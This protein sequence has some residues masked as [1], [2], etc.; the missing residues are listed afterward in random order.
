MLLKRK[1]VWMRFQLGLMVKTFLDYST[2]KDLRCMR[3][4]CAGDSQKDASGQR[5]TGQS[6]VV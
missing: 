3:R 2:S 4:C 5:D 6:M 1:T